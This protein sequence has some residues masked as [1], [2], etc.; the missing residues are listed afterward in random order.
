MPFLLGGQVSQTC[1][2]LFGKV[3]KPVDQQ[4]GIKIRKKT[5]NTLTVFKSF[6][7]LKNIWCS[8]AKK[9]LIKK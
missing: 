5:E 4:E 6:F 7:E 2:E 9:L 3:G 8:A 1:T